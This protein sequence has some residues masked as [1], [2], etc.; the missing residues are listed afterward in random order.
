V[1]YRT[2][3]GGCVTDVPVVMARAHLAT[4]ERD[5]LVHQSGK[6]AGVRKPESV[7]ALTRE[8]EQLF[9]KAYHLLLNQLVEVLGRRLPAA[10]VE[11]ILQ[12][13]GRDLA[14]AQSAV[15]EGKPF[16]QRLDHALQVLSGMGGLAELK[17]HEGGLVIQGCSCPMGD[18]VREHP[19]VCRLAEA[20][21]T[22]IVGVPVR[23]A[24]ERN[25]AP[26]CAFRIE[27]Q[28]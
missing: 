17:E 6:R 1:R 3:T 8:A 26:R 11:E 21:L 27:T 9:P 20:L 28:N 10:A 2:S 5:G 19:E 24:C 7:Y 14:A 25:G 13:V 4:L 18:A 16:R 22:E 23:E 15:F 12:E